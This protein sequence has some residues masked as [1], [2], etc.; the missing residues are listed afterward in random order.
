[1]QCHDAR[2]VTGLML[3]PNKNSFAS[4]AFFKSCCC[5]TV[6]LQINVNKLKISQVY[7]IIFPLISDSCVSA[8]QLLPVCNSCYMTNV[9]YNIF[10]TAV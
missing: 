8:N 1:M 6:E 10:R 5:S 2:E 9:S 3:I 4:L 7:K